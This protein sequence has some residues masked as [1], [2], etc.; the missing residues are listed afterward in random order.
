MKII[1]PG[2]SGQVGQVLARHF[3]GQGHDVVVLC[4]S[5]Q[6]PAGRVVSWDGRTLGGWASEI[7]GA[8]VVINLAG[9]TVNCRYTEEN[10]RQMMDSRVEST[11]V[12]GQAI[13]RASRPPKLWLQMST[14]TIYAHR[15]DA[16][17]DEATGIIG[18]DELDVPSYWAYSVQIAKNW[19]QALN[20]AKTPSTRK[21]ALRTSMVMSPDREG[22]FDVMS[23]L[24]R[25]GLGG[26][27]AGGNQFVSWIHDK[28]FVRAIE[29]LMAH[30][31]MDGP[32]NV[33]SPGPLPYND[34]MRAMR[35]AWGI[36]LG[37]PATKW[38]LE[39]GAWAMRTDTELVLK[40]RRVVPGR[41]L[42][43]GFAF[44]FTEWSKAAK[45][46]V[47]RWRAQG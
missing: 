4:R 39:I 5:A 16:P 12:V 21:I 47:A 11:R 7:D 13:E 10:L 43:K 44:D 19:E 33:A 25:F 24:V 36:R 20:E 46:L 6:V 2:G 18:G 9:R 37:L 32:V 30:E 42:E 23:G 1:I 31:E 26:S 29:F 8:D 40:S 22:I 3:V 38:M 41:L 14:A 17:N 35:D 34:F 27:A 45:D 15:F 28:D